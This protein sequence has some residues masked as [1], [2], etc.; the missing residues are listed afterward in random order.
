MYGARGG[1]G[2]G[3]RSQS[4]SAA[5]TPG[6]G[7]SLDLLTGA[8][9]APAVPQGRPRST[10]ARR[11]VLQE[12]PIAA[13]NV[14]GN[15]RAGREASTLQQQRLDGIEENQEGAHDVNDQEGQGS[16]DH[17]AQVQEDE[18]DEGSRFGTHF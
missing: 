15:S 4:Q 7:E 9:V 5:T 1:H 11:S 10:N 18:E 16:Y 6:G 17:R 3:T 14:Y 2:Y 13:Q 8:P 12:Q